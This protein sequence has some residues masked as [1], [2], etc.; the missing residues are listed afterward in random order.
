MHWEYQTVKLNVKGVW[1]VSFDEDQ[2]Q[3]FTNRLGAQGWELV[4]AFAVN[5][6]NGYSKEVVFIF[7][8]PLDE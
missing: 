7:K 1:G 3:E 5:D 6:G 2:T 4:S 8:R